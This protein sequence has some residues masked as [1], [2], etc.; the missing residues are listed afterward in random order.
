LQRHGINYLI[1]V[2]AVIH[3]DADLRRLT[4]ADEIVDDLSQA[5]NL[6]ILVL[7]TSRVNPLADELSRLMEL[8]RGP[9]VD[10]GIARM[11]AATMGSPSSE[12]ERYDTKRRCA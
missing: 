12:P 2:D 7:D 9:P 6:R 4:R 5:K 11:I 10:R 1:P 8:T 3:D